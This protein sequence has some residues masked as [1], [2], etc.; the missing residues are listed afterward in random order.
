[1]GVLSQVPDSQVT[2]AIGRR[3]HRDPLRHQW[4]S[5]WR[6]IQSLHQGPTQKHPRAISAFREVRQIRRATSA[7]GR[8]SVKA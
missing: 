3:P 6:P 5:G 4:P 1:L 2:T 7:K 8:I